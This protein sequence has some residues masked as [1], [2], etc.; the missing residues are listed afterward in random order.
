MRENNTRF[1]TFYK[2]QYVNIR[3]FIRNFVINSKL[4]KNHEPIPQK[5]APFCLKRGIYN[6]I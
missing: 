4:L 2:L 6:F 3:C 5:N 1:I